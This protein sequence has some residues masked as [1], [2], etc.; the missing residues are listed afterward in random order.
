MLKKG[1]RNKTRLPQC[2]AVLVHGLLKLVNSDQKISQHSVQHAVTLIGQCISQKCYAFF[3]FLFST[4]MKQ[5]H[6]GVQW[7]RQCSTVQH[8]E[9]WKKTMGNINVET[10]LLWDII[11][12]SVGI[13][14]LT[15]LWLTILSPL[16]FISCVNKITLRHITQIHHRSY[17]LRSSAFFTT[18]LM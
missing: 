5:T 12:Y 17:A 9:F 11:T 7:T 8:T 3:V 13:V 18:A 16:V 6:R 1:L 10:C 2:Y 15:T 4:C 14:T